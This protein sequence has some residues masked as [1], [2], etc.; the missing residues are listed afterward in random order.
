M[1]GMARMSL[2][3]VFGLTLAG[4]GPAAAQSAPPPPTV[5]MAAAETQPAITDESITSVVKAKLESIKLLRHAQVIVATENG[6]VTLVGIVP[7]DFAR[8][9]AVDAARN[10]V[11]VVRVDDQ[12]RMDIS[13]PQAPTRN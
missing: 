8:V 10:T 6:V 7:N 9:Q 1:K 12:L 2:W 13:S 11:G 4:V 5:A 3:G